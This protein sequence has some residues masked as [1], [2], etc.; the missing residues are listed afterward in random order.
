MLHDICVGKT[1][2]LTEGKMTV[3]KFHITDHQDVKSNDEKENP[4]TYFNSNQLDINEDLKEIIRESIICN[5]DVRIE[6]NDELCIYEPKGQPIETSMI[7][8]LMDNEE[9][10]HNKFIARNQFSPKIV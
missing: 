1:G 10:I 6:T 8:F 2:T 3:A 9:D 7:Q 4:L 5:T